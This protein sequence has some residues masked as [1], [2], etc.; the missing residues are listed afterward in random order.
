MSYKMRFVE[1][2]IF[3]IAEPSDPDIIL[4]KNHAFLNLDLLTGENK[5]I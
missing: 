2:V 5:G 4:F 1:I 3:D